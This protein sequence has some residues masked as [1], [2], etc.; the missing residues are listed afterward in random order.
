VK[1]FL[2]NFNWAVFENEIKWGWTEPEQGKV[3]FVPSQC[4]LFL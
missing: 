1:F 4:F 2:E 3:K